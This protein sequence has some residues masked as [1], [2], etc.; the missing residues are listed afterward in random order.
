MKTISLVVKKL[1]EDLVIQWDNT[2][3]IICTDSYF[4][5]VP[6]AE[7]L[8]K[9]RLRFI[10]VIKTEMRKFLMAYPSNI[11][12][13]NWGDMSGFLTRTVDRTDPVLGAFVWMDQNMW[14]FI[15]TVG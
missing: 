8:W 11:E 1:L 12:F 6:A 10:G 5:S 3:R 14:C 13:Q 2:D 9:H 4:T 7:K 15:F